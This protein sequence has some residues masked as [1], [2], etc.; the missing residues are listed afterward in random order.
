MISPIFRRII[1]RDLN[2]ITS[3]PA[4]ADRPHVLQTTNDADRRQHA[5]NTVP[6]GGPVMTY[7]TRC[8]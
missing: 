3:I 1:L 8:V 7:I 5:N 4:A 6:L 2:T